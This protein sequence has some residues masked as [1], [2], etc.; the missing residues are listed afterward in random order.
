MAVFAY[1][2]KAHSSLTVL[3]NT[4]FLFAWGVRICVRGVPH[5]KDTFVRPSACDTG[6]SKTVWTWVLCAPTVFAVAFDEDELLQGYPFI[7]TFLC[8]YALIIDIVDCVSTVKNITR[9]PYVFSS[10]AMSWGLYLIHP[11]LWTILFPLIFSSIVV[12]APAGFRWNEVLLQ[13]KMH[14]DPAILEYVRGTS[15]IF[16]MP[17]GTYK[18]VPMVLKRLVFCEF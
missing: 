2:I 5:V 13:S 14:S 9:N 6:V 10:L 4:G 7:G 15:P 11:S 16:P 3:L 18:T 8:L 17:S 12:R 1:F